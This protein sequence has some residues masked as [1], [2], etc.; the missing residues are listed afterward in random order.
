MPKVAENGEFKVKASIEIA[1]LQQQILQL[2][3]EITE[4]KTNH[5]VHLQNSL[6]SIE[7]EVITMRL[8]IARWGA[9]GAS[10]LFLGQAIWAYILSRR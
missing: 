9:I 3:A 5:L 10:V 8:T 1:R 7:D 2:Q 6:T 4:V